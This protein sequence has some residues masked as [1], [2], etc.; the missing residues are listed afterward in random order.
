MTAIDGFTVLCLLLAAF[1]F[2]AGTVGILRFPSALT[3]IH[4]VAKADNLGLG[5][6]VLGLLPRAE[7]PAG[8][9]RLLLVWLLALMASA[10]A[11]YLIA[12]S[13]AAAEREAESR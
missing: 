13:A 5:L 4:A 11:S 6:V 9:A 2:L 3:R 7:S 8:A 1:F 12:S 10:T